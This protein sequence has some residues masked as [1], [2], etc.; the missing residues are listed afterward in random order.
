MTHGRAHLTG[1]L[2]HR[3]VSACGGRWPRCHPGC[4]RSPG[5]LVPVPDPAGVGLVAWSGWGAR[6]SRPAGA[7]KVIDRW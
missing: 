2:S 7:V 6:G 5:H 1:P 3:I 4:G